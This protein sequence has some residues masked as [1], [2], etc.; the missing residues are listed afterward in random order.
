LDNLARVTY[1]SGR[2]IA[3]GYDNANR[4]QRVS[5]HLRQSRSLTLGRVAVVRIHVARVRPPR[6]PD[7]RERL[8]VRLLP[9]HLRLRSFNGISM[10]YD[11]NGNLET[12]PVATFA[13][14]PANPTRSSTVAGTT[15]T[16]AYDADDWRVKKAV[17]GGATTYYLRG[18][19]GEL[20]SEWRNTAPNAQVRD[21][22]YAGGR[23]IA[24]FAVAQPAR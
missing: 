11:A 22:V 24:V 14:T 12:A 13:Y 4:V 20:L 21:Y 23:L 5:F 3:Y 6:E 16:F 15:T 1:P 9:R 18:A 2:K 10:T 19:G 7:E 17:A 8:D